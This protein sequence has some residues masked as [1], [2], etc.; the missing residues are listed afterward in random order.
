MR[1]PNFGNSYRGGGLAAELWQGL[2][3]GTLAPVAA[4]LATA[5]IRREWSGRRG[6]A[7]RRGVRVS[8]AIPPHRSTFGIGAAFG[9]LR[10]V[11]R[12]PG[13]TADLALDPLSLPLANNLNNFSHAEHCPKSLDSSS[14]EFGNS[15]GSLPR[16]L[17]GSIRKLRYWRSSRELTERIAKHHAPRQRRGDTLTLVTK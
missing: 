9:E 4:I 11:P 8:L 16:S 2:I 12:S 13:E 17:I 14:S 3:T 5:I 1:T 7:R 10:H 15:L 6:R